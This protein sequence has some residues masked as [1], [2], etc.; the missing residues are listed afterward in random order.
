MVIEVGQ[1]SMFFFSSVHC[2]IPRSK[3]DNLK[4]VVHPYIFEAFVHDSTFTK[5]VFCM[6][7]RTKCVTKS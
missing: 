6:L 2:M 4:Q 1:V 5:A 3:C 7:R